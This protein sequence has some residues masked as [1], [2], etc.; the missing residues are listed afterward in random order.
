MTEDQN[1]AT[2]GG[3]AEHGVDAEASSQPSAEAIA[4]PAVTP[5]PTEAG[6]VPDEGATP[7][8]GVPRSDGAHD[9]PA[10]GTYAM[11]ASRATPRS[12]AAAPAGA[13]Y[14]PPQTG[15]EPPPA[16]YAGFGTPGWAAPPTPGG[17]PAATRTT[18][19]TLSWP[20]PRHWSCWERGSAS[21]TPRP[22]AG[23]TPSPWRRRRG[24][25]RALPRRK[26]KV[27]GRT[28]AR[29]I[30]GEPLRWDLRQRQLRGNSGN[31]GNSGSSSSNS[32]GPSDV[33]AI[34]SKVDPGL[35]D[36]NTTLGYQQ[37][38][39]AGTGIVLSSGGS[40]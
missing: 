31:S 20:E 39:A 16:G 36:I 10:Q 9:T 25:A 15:D 28:A 13:P 38:Q 32:S 17:A 14:V 27:V 11:G 1:E 23:R 18:S 2:S 40:C 26:W 6:P 22:R 3:E 37:E 29:T 35:V 7:P 5:P 33:N 24:P 4:L 21:A 34:A 30:L 8:Q 12:G 19:V